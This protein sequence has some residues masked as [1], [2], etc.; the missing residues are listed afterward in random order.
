MRSAR[1]PSI[2][3]ELRFMLGVDWLAGCI[4][5]VGKGL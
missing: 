1:A 5:I 4:E 3:A 2:Q